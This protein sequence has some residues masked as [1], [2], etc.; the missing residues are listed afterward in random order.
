MR[1]ALVVGLVLATLMAGCSD[2]PNPA[3]EPDDPRRSAGLVQN[4]ERNELLFEGTLDIVGQGERTFSVTIPNGTKALY[5]RHIPDEHAIVLTSAFVELVGCGRWD[6]EAG[7]G[8]PVYRNTIEYGDLCGGPTPGAAEFK[9][10]TAQGYLD[11]T[12]Q[13]WGR[14]PPHGA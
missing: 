8:T 7:A 9:A 10:G 14:M 4:E 6:A 5:F 1:V 3:E 12:L 13:L 2:P 11:G